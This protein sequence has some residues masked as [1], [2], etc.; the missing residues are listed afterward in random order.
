[1]GRFDRQKETAQSDRLE[2][3]HPTGTCKMQ[4]GYGAVVLVSLHAHSQCIGHRRRGLEAPER[5]TKGH[6]VNRSAP[7]AEANRSAYE[8]VSTTQAPPGVQW[9]FQ[10]LRR[11]DPISRYSLQHY[12]GQNHKGCITNSELTYLS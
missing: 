11:W 8:P 12:L 9:I 2:K 7:A 10:T 6:E 3:D 5:T 1:M 4:G